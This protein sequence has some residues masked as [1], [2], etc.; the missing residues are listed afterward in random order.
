MMGP[1]AGLRPRPFGPFIRA[2]TSM[3][4]RRLAPFAALAVAATA[5]A[6]S[7]DG[8]V[9]GLAS[10]ARAKMQEYGVPGVAIGII[11]NGQTYIRPLGVTS[12][13]D[14][15]QVNAHTVFPIA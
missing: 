14:S 15:V 6:Q 4:I 8:R 7:N 5:P 2:M 12:L 10:L 3:T 1:P 11:Y 9:D 13:E